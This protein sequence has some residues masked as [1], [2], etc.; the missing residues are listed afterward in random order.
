GDLGDS[1][2][3]DVS[4]VARADRFVR[5]A[6]FAASGA[7]GGRR[8]HPRFRSDALLRE[9]VR[10]ARDGF[11]RGAAHAAHVGADGPRK[12]LFVMIAFARVWRVLSVLAVL[13]MSSSALAAVKLVGSWPETDKLVTLDASGLPK[14]EAVR[15]IADGAGWSVVWASPSVEPVDIHVK[16]Q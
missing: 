15:R 4:R 7:R 3:L 8:G 13:S 16:K 6:R 1:G 9:H 12:G 14:A 5:G 11:C 10:L 2:A